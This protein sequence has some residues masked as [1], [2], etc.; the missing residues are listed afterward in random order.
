M[1]L[2][3]GDSAPDFVFNDATGQERAFADFHAT[4]AILLLTPGSASAEQPALQHLTFRGESIPVMA[5]ADERTA[6]VY[7]VG[8]DAAVF[9]ISEG[10]ILW[11]HTIDDAGPSH[12]RQ[13]QPIS[14]G[15]SSSRCWRL[16][17]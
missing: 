2:G 17:R 14:R 10:K 5:P 8:D 4:P 13:R 1:P 7:G 16:R 15:A 6:R 11:S 12:V 3:I 9:V